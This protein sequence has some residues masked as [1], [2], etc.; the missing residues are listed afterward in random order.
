MDSPPWPNAKPE[1]SLAGQAAL[2]CALQPLVIPRAKRLPLGIGIVLSHPAAFLLHGS[3]SL[4]LFQG[5]AHSCSLG[6]VPRSPAGEESLPHFGRVVYSPVTFQHHSH[7]WGCQS[8]LLPTFLG[9]REE[10]WRRGGNGQGLRVCLS[11]VHTCRPSPEDTKEGS[12]RARC[13]PQED[14]SD[15]SVE[16]TS[17]RCLLSSRPDMRVTWSRREAEG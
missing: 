4:L 1:L 9:L 11:P 2:E 12:D 8:A 3:R 7:F 17:Q 15:C 5:P 10:R 14:P 16:G 13:A 6:P